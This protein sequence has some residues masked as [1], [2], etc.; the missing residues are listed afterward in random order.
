MLEEIDQ[1]RKSEEA[2]YQEGKRILG[3]SVSLVQD[4]LD[5]Y[6][7]IVDMI[8]EF[9]V[10]PSDEIVAASHFLLGCRYQLTLGTLALLRGHLT[11]SF[12]FSRKAI[13]LC[14][15]AARVKKHPHLARIWLCVTRDDA[16]YEKYRKK[17]SPGKLFPED[18]ALVGELSDRYDI[19]SKLIHPSLYSFV[20]HIEPEQTETEFNIKFNYFQ[21]K[22]DDP[23]EP[24]GTLL[25]VVD[26]HFRI[27]RVFEE[28]FSDVIA[29]DRKKW[30]IR[31]NAVEGKIATH[32]E[33]W[34]PVVMR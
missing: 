31:R 28:V 5:L 24:I 33:K 20:G 10:E 15:F 16:S 2:N 1:I 26:T 23:S 22:N 6:N 12:F 14:A 13:E 7:L 29:Y 11:D 9:K 17:F 3:E 8:K 25:W 4:L 34:K 21:L 27:L 30:E 32:K 18:H 19:C